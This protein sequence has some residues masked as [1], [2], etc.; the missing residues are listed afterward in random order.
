M[1][2]KERKNIMDSKAVKSE[3]GSLHKLAVGDVFSQENQDYVVWFLNESRAQIAPLT[4]EIEYRIREEDGRIQFLATKGSEN[5][6]PNSEFKILRSLGRSGLKDEIDRLRKEQPTETNMKKKTKKQKGEGT[7]GIRS[8]SLGTYKNY[9]IASVVRT[10]GKAGW[11]V[12]EVRAWL[13]K[14]GIKASDQTIK[15]NIYRG[16]KGV[17]GELAPLKKDEFPTKPVVESSKAPAKTG[18]KDKKGAKEKSSSK[19]AKAKASTGTKSSKKSDKKADG[20]DTSSKPEGR[21]AEQIAKM[22]EA[23]A[24]KKA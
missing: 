19:K 8:G 17:D 9:S 7:P 20:K 22:K 15:L 12:P 5:V 14:E 21:A 4:G 1:V 3:S 6:S 2:R 10:L 18:K 11:K 24:A 23:R 16:V 13:D